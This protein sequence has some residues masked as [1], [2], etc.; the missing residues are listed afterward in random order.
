[1]STGATSARREHAERVE[2]VAGFTCG[3]LAGAA[4]ALLM[5]P[6]PGRETRQWIATQ[7][8]AAR[9]RTGQL[10]HAEQLGAI[11]RRSGVVGLADVLRRRRA[12]EQPATAG[13]PVEQ[14]IV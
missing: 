11:I 5:A 9:R 13:D 7:G 8:R 6:A 1:M 12:D 2:F 14:P 3:V 10:L 4:L